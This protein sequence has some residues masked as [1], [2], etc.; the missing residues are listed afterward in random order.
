MNYDALFNQ[1]LNLP[2]ESKK[3]EAN[4]KNG[5]NQLQWSNECGQNKLLMLVLL[6]V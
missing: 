6:C 2:L 5:E 3:L 1:H 4:Q